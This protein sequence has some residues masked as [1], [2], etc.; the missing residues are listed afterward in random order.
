MSPLL[1]ACF[2]LGYF[3]FLMAI[4]WWT[5]R[6]GDS[7]EAFFIGNRQSPW[8]VVAFGMIGTSL[9][10]VTFISVPGSVQGAQF[11]Y[12]QMVLGYLLGYL[13]VGLVLMPLY[14]R[15][16]LTSIY[17]YLLNR[18]GMSSYK[19][20][21]WFFLISR[22]IGASFRLYLVAMVFQLAIFDPLKIEMPFALTVLITIT[23]IWVYSF[24]GGIK[25]IVW[26]DTLQTLF[27]LLA[28]VVTIIVIGQQMDLSLPNLVQ[29][30]QHSEYSKVF[31]FEDVNDNRYF[32][33]QFLAGA[34]MTI[35]MTGL[36]QDMMQK[37]LTCKNLGDA[38]KNMFWFSLTLVVVNGFFLS[39]GAL[40][41]IYSA[42]NGIV[43]PEKLDQLYPL[44]A[45]N[46]YLGTGVALLFVL[47]L[48]AAAYSSADSALT[49]LTT[50]FCVDILGFDRNKIENPAKTRKMVHLSISAVLLIVIVVFKSFDDASVINSLF[51]IA[52]YTYGPLL[53]LFCFG[54]FTKLSLKDKWVPIVCLV[55]PVLSYV[56]QA[57]SV[58]WFNGYKVGFELLI[59]NGLLTFLGLLLLVNK[60]DHPIKS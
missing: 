60:K 53:G 18:F 56:L 31:F 15:L 4:S 52:G 5:T 9:S 35:A 41:F 58:Q 28:V 11:S 48:I 26:T 6:S 54:L 14:Y 19:T 34:F 57:N 45:V 27:M 20:G 24:K 10:G 8:F 7:N 55:A 46:G 30:I 21:S 16:N 51:K 13:V 3:G 42:S 25:T 47:G 50:S 32:W 39:L 40:L 33:K 36:D 49:A 2:V 12:M 43:I 23:L 38:Q 1:I 37:N 17:T 59:I 29:T 22:I 44:L